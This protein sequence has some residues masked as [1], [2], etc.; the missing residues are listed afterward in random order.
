MGQRV[1]GYEARHL[2]N[3]TPVPEFSRV[4]LHF[5]TRGGAFF[6][7]AQAM[8]EVSV[9]VFSKDRP[10]QARPRDFSS[11]TA[12]FDDHRV[13]P[14]AVRALSSHL[15]WRPHHGLYKIPS[16]FKWGARAR[17]LD[18]PFVAPSPRPVLG[19][20]ACAGPRS[21]LQVNMCW[22]RSTQ[23]GE[24]LRTLFLFSHGATLRVTVL[25][26]IT[27]RFPPAARRALPLSSSDLY[28]GFAPHTGIQDPVSVSERERIP[29]Y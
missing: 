12:R 14:G 4:T 25:A 8:V 28:Q 18:A 2:R 1:A 23:L 9:L 5:L 29:V 6:R 3:C 26:A 13:L 16:Q 7:T 24:Y 21:Q 27:T 19:A 17:T 20:R 15:R 11:E 22:H 10:F